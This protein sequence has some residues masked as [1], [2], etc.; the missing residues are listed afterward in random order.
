MLPEIRALLIDL[1]GVIY[2]GEL[3]IPG[4]AEAIAELP[5]LD[6]KH[7]F[8]TNNATLRPEEFAT[9]LS[10]RRRST[11][12]ARRLRVGSA[13]PASMQCRARYAS[14][15]RT[16]CWNRPPRASAKRKVSCAIWLRPLSITSF[17]RSSP[18]TSTP[19]WTEG[20]RR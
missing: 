3:A 1:D 6:V 17:R 16:T 5:R 13:A 8:V 14:H 7:I 10:R 19:R 11:Y 15:L 18:S 20:P 12:R 9:K 4:A 2:R